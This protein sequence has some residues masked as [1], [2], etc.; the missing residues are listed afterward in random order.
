MKT[1]F[2]NIIFLFDIFLLNSDMAWLCQCIR[3]ANQGNHFLIKFMQSVIAHLLTNWLFHQL[4]RVIIFGDFSL[5]FCVFW[6]HFFK[7]LFK[8]CK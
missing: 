3:L 5:V 7:E 8:E 2:D 6:V 1:I 4:N